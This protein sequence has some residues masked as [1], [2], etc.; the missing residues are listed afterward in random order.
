MSRKKTAEVRQVVLGADALDAVSAVLGAC[1]EYLKVSQEEQTKRVEIQAQKEV[2]LE[3]LR[4]QKE[5]ILHYLD[6]SFDERRQNFESFFETLDRTIESGNAAQTSAVLDSIVNLA[7]TSPFQ[8]VKEE[9]RSFLN[10]PK[11]E[12]ELEF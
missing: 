7:K 2:V 9:I 3:N 5:V 6:R 10:N 8:D 1:S 4:S 11:A 12:L